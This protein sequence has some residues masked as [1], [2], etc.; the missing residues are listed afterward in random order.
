VKAVMLRE[1][2][3]S[4]FTLQIQLGHA[5]DESKDNIDAFN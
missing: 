2:R 3:R 5:E 1:R 4:S